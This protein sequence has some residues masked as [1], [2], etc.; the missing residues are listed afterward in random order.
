MLATRDAGKVS[1][2]LY[3]K[4]QKIVHQSEEHELDFRNFERFL[5]S[6]PFRKNKRMPEWN[7]PVDSA[8]PDKYGCYHMQYWLNE[9]LIAINVIDILP[10]CVSSVYF[11]YDPDYSFLNLGT[12]SSLREIELVRKLNKFN[13]SIKYYYMGF[14]IHSCVKMRYKGNINSSYLL[15]PETY[16]FHDYKWCKEKFDLNRT[17]RLT[18]DESV[19]D[20][21]GIINVNDVRILFKETAMTYQIYKLKFKSNASEQELEVQKREIEEYARL[22]GNSFIFKNLLYLTE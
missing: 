10:N 20:S 4:Y 13:P 16:L 5:I 17:C 18:V 8:L 7:V 6:N 12:Y 9:K 2:E 21:E 19:T 3:K 22:V 11:F 15:C 14:Y 1:H